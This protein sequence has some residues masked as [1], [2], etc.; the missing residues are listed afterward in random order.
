MLVFSLVISISPCFAEDSLPASSEKQVQKGFF[1][2]ISYSAGTGLSY[3]NG[4]YREI[5]YTNANSATP[6]LSE[7]LWNLD[8][9]FLLNFTA[10]ASKGPWSLNLSV[11]TAVTEGSGIMED[12][13]WGDYSKTEWTN[14]SR[15]LIFL[16]K[17]VFLDINSSYK[18]TLN[19]SFSFPVKLGYKLNYLDWEDKSGEYIYYWD[20][21]AGDYYND[22]PRTGDFGGV[23]GIDYKVIQNIFYASSGI[24]F[25]AGDMTIGL[26]IALSPLIY[27]WDLDHHI[28]TN[29]FYLDSFIAHL[30]YRPEATVN[31]RLNP[32]G[33]ISFTAF[34]E[35]LPETKGDIYTYTEDP[36]DSEEIGY[37]VGYSVGAAGHASILWGIGLSYIWTF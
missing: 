13:D 36:S 33:R 1:S 20:F 28:F 32:N 4:Q 2:D 35:E 23:N 27:A 25:N 31:I 29:T 17:S 24:L 6:Y 21:L 5:V 14:W 15:S 30:W 37:Q 9:V 16:D 10:G 22:P 7:L 26:N 34:L 19:N 3:L 11:G 18:F 8:N 12:Y